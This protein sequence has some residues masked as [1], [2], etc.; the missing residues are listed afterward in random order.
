MTDGGR[1]VAGERGGGGGEGSIEPLPPETSPSVDGEGMDCSSAMG[2]GVEVG[3][4]K[5]LSPRTIAMLSPPEESTPAAALSVPTFKSPMSPSGSE[6]SF[7]PNTVPVYLVISSVCGA[8]E[9][10]C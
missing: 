9:T 1:Y 4:F 6:P 2:E 5:P 7:K 8:D 10:S 3:A